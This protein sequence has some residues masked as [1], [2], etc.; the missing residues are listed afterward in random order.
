MGAENLLRYFRSSRGSGTQRG[1][2]GHVERG[3]TFS[4]KRVLVRRYAD[5]HALRSQISPTKTQPAMPTAGA[6][7]KGPDRLET[8]FFVSPAEAQRLVNSGDA[9][10]VRDC[11]G[12]I[13]EE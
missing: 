5:I 7:G 3:D 2:K 11:H 10:F 8:D 6:P 9:M 4:E 12:K 13:V 1:N